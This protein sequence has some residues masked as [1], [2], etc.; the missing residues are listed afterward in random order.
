[1][2]KFITI[3]ILVPQLCYAQIYNQLVDSLFGS[4]GTSYSIIG[5]TT[6]YDNHGNSWDTIGDT[7]YGNDGS[8]YDR[9][10]DT[11]FDNSGNTWNQIGDF[12]HGSDGTICV[13]IGGM[14]SCN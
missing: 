13:N 8:I 11:V 4:D 2:L 9:V 12:T 5:D 14:L 7:T 6:I 10:G 3:I 1:M